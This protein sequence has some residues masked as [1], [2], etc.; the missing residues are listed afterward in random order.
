[1][2]AGAQ[3]DWP[4]TQLSTVEDPGCPL[5]HRQQQGGCRRGRGQGGAQRA[6]SCRDE[7]GWLGTH[8]QKQGEKW[9]RHGGEDVGGRV[10]QARLSAL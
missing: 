6:Q 7:P 9:E 1:M 8:K 4:V 5:P 3:G 2:A 10:G